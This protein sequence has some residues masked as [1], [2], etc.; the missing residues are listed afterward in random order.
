MLPKPVERPSF[1]GAAL[2]IGA[3]YMDAKRQFSVPVFDSATGRYN[4]Q[5][6]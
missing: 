1:L 3:G 4:L 2:R 6:Y 5:S